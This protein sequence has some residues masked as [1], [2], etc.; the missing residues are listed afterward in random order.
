MNKLKKIISTVK[1][2]QLCRIIGG[3]GLTTMGLY[4]ICNYWE[5]FGWAAC[6]RFICRYYPEEYD[7]IM[8]KVIEECN[9]H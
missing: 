3:I 1:A 8:G 9:K 5:Q 4:L 7:A 2:K 6:Q